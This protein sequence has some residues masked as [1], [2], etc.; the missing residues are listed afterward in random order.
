MN[1][2]FFSNECENEKTRLAK[3]FYP[4]I[5][6][7]AKLGRLFWQHVL[8]FRRNEQEKRKISFDN[9]SYT[10]LPHW[11]TKRDRTDLKGRLTILVKTKMARPILFIAVNIWRYTFDCVNRATIALDTSKI[12]DPFFSS[13]LPQKAKIIRLVLWNRITQTSQNALF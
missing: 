6:V 10:L 3:S 12:Q 13:F 2:C 8:Q 11:Q 7:N 4:T 1:S 5:H 9:S